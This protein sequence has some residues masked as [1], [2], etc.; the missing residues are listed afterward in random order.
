MLFKKYN[1][2]LFDDTLCD[3]HMHSTWT[4][5]EGTIEENILRAKELGLLK[6]AATDH[7]RKDSIYFKDYT[8]EIKRLRDKH[9][10]DIKIGFEAK[11]DNFNGDIDVSAENL[12]NAEI[13]ICS[14]HR[15]PIGRK[16]IPA[17]AFSAEVSQEIELELSIAALN[18]GGFNT[19]GHPGGMSIR[20]HKE[21]KKEYF[22]EIISTCA[23]TNIAFDF[24]ASYHQDVKVTLKELFEKYNPYISL[25]SDAHRVEFI[26][27]ATKTLF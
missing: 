13:S 5:G 22:E 20:A 14:V 16:L 27:N 10:F 6:I 19:L 25:G 4:D 3:M 26:G 7:I 1:E 2:I 23:K 11:V 12:K 21:F 8:T 15:F 24:N 17:K 9:E 18:K